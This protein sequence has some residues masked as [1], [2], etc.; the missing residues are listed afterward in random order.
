[1]V[2]LGVRARYDV[3]LSHWK[4]GKR[5]FRFSVKSQK[6]TKL[7]L[8]SCSQL[9]DSSPPQVILR[10]AGLSLSLP[11]SITATREIS[12]FYCTRNRT[13]A[14]VSW[15]V[16]ERGQT[17]CE[18]GQLRYPIAYTGQSKWSSPGVF[19][20]YSAP[21]VSDT[22]RHG[23]S[24]QADWFNG[25]VIQLCDA[26][27]V[28]VLRDVLVPRYGPSALSLVSSEGI[29]PD[30]RRQFLIR[31]LDRGAIPLSR[32]T[33]KEKKT[34][35]LCK[36]RRA[37]AGRS[38]VIPAM[39]W[40]RDSVSPLLAAVCPVD[41]EQ[42]HPATPSTMIGD[43]TASVYQ[44]R[45]LAS[46]QCSPYTVFDETDI[47][48]L[49]KGQG[50]ANCDFPW[51]DKW[52]RQLQSLELT[53]R[54][55]D[56][57][58]E[59]E[60]NAPFEAEDRARIIESWKVP[61]ERGTETPF[62]KLIS[63][64]DSFDLPRGVQPPL[65]IHR[66]FRNHPLLR[67]KHWNRCQY[68]LVEFLNDPDVHEQARVMGKSFWKWAREKWEGFSRKVR[69]AVASLPIWPMLD[70]EFVPLAAMCYP[71]RRDIRD[72]FRSVILVPSK[73]VLRMPGVRLG[74]RG[75]MAIRTAISKEETEQWFHERAAAFRMGQELDDT[76]QESFGAFEAELAVLASDGELA[77]KLRRLRP[78]ALGL[79]QTGRL[80][81]VHE[82]HRE[83]AE[84]RSLSLRPEDLIRR[85]S[86]KV[87]LIFEARTTASFDALQRAIQQ[88]PKKVS[89]WVKRLAAY[90]KA[91]EREGR[92][93]NIGGF[94]CICVD[95]AWRRPSELALQGRV[96]NFWGRWKITIP[97]KDK[98]ADEQTILRKVG[99]GP[100][101][102]DPP[103]SQAFFQWLQHQSSQVISEHLP[104]VIRHFG[105]AN[106]VL[107]WWERLPHIAC[108]PVINGSIVRLA[109]FAI[110]TDKYRISVC[111]DDFP[112][113]S[114]EMRKNGSDISFVIDR[115]PTLSISVVERIHRIA[116]NRLS[117]V[118]SEPIR[119][120]GVGQ[121]K[122][123]RDLHDL[124]RF[125]QSP[126]F[127]RLFSGSVEKLSFV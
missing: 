1:V 90:I 8:R 56:I 24:Q 61:D 50:D 103:T 34:R 107:S 100:S 58:H 9:S 14:E 26:A 83:T 91:A 80:R 5:R 101:E 17:L 10:E 85:A 104:Q 59:A 40:K 119:V 65:L 96:G 32:R 21:F 2:R 113:L 3:E 73:E 97:V 27:L 6:K 39:T 102:P 87:D 125:M 122:P 88:P 54:I 121:S 15:S 55:F 111:I 124:L 16:D 110:A 46:N 68:G 28:D 105:H 112:E 116:I 69:L 75:G 79:D 38:F 117:R 36:S 42:I 22:E 51:S 76:A 33:R 13:A 66:Q 37:R 127:K 109:S 108:L 23:I 19:A 18:P 74:Q 20:S 86:T 63:T 41:N 7:F 82:L 94:A 4:L 92:T 52:A 95:G 120:T 11:S 77:S 12:E 44:D 57:L 118:A 126:Q 89:D 84:I 64:R 30:R 106:G 70:A 115:H 45:S 53:R 72:L 49:I 25:T 67:R 123:S 93:P 78:H 43:L 60:K 71:K 98:S 47:I 99:V 31:L 81:P 62:G 35:M 29:A 48:G 114:Q